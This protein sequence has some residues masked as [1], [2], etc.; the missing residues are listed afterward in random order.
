MEDL[1]TYQFLEDHTVD[2]LRALDSRTQDF[3]NSNTVDIKMIFVYEKASFGNQIRQKIF[4]AVLLAHDWAA[5]GS[6]YLFNV[7]DVFHFSNN[8]G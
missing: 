2:N 8:S 1:F 3:A 7:L 6:L 4:I 5:D